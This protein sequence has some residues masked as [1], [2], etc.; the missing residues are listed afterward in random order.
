MN[1][2]GYNKAL[3]NR[4]SLTI[5]IS[6]AVLDNWYSEEEPMRGGQYKYSDLCIESI[7]SLKNVLR[8]PYRQTI[9]FVKSLLELMGESLEVP[10]YTQLC[11]RSAFLDIV[12]LSGKKSGNLDI[13]VDSTG[14]KV[15]GE[16]EWKVRKHGYTKRRTWRKL[17]LAVD[18]KT[19]LIHACDL[20]GNDVDDAAQVEEL[21][22]NVEGEI[23]TFC[24]DGAYDR[25][26]IWNLLEEKGIDAIIPPRKNA[27][28]WL[29]GDGELI[30]HQRNRILEWIDLLGSKWWKEKFGYHKRSLSETAM[31]RFK[32]I[33]GS[34]L[35]S[36]KFKKQ[37]I[38]AKLK[39]KIINQFTAMGMPV[40]ICWD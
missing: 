29:D 10:S 17:H 32:T 23:T 13:V 4:G 3:E 1:W 2:S 14:L 24:G 9:G 36:R 37:A 27:N 33:F 18:P 28:Y 34:E 12:I 26:H 25:N 38:E 8:L 30:E 31:Y 16:G 35:Y 7:M 21:L 40:S 39:I 20:T 19:N 22:G 15:Y 6:E 11:R 5:W